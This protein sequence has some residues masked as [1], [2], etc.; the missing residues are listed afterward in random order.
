MA[1]CL[2]SGPS[3]SQ[4]KGAQLQVLTDEQLRNV[5]GG[6]F[7]YQPVAEIV[8]TAQDTPTAVADVARQLLSR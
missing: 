8:Q 7:S 2:K 5:A 6:I 3:E 4:A 1:L